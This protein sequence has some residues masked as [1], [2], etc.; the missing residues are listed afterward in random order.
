M[1][2]DLMLALDRF[3]SDRRARQFHIKPAELDADLKRLE[4]LAGKLAELL[5]E[6]REAADAM[7][8]V[9]RAD[10]DRPQ[11]L[12]SPTGPP[13]FA[14]LAVEIETAARRAQETP[15]KHARY[16]DTK[17]GDVALDNLLAR[18]LGFWV[19]HTG[20]AP[21]FAGED[22]QRWSPFVRFALACCRHLDLRL[23]PAGLAKRGARV[24][25]AAPGPKPV[26]R[27][28]PRGPTR[29]ATGHVVRKRRGEKS[30]D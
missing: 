27:P 7:L 9:A 19:E 29:R 15:P 8:R 13:M 3:R 11:L 16:I 22:E 6:K 18:L 24:Y 21:T 25:A 28:R 23:T 17:R 12:A 2:A 5:H 4:R 20:T 1:H 14:A 30:R 10:H 26:K